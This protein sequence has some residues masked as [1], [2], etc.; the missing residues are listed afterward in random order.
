MP[1]DHVLYVPRSTYKQSV[2]LNRF[3]DAG[4]VTINSIE[5]CGQGVGEF[6]KS[7][8]LHSAEGSELEMDS[9]FTAHDGLTGIFVGITLDPRRL[10]L[11]LQPLPPEGVEIPLQHPVAFE[12]H[13]SMGGGGED[14]GKKRRGP[15]GPGGEL[16]EKHTDQEGHYPDKLEVEVAQSR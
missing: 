4:V 5:P 9:V 16:T 14:D 10:R 1:N 8:R 2:K 7:F 13:F 11:L 12:V 3:F 15:T 6:P